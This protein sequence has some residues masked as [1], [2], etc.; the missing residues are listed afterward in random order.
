MTRD[1]RDDP[2]YTCSIP[3][4][5]SARAGIPGAQAADCSTERLLPNA[6]WECSLHKVHMRLEL[7]LFGQFQ[8][9]WGGQSIAFAANAARAVL[10]YL[11]LDP[12]RP[13]QREQ[14]AAL[15]WPDMPQAA[16][17][18]NL[19][20]VLSRVRKALPDVPDVQA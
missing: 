17:Y 2:G 5:G 11:A 13:H 16:A 15:L 6:A 20:Q 14:L 12:D 3:G 1:K 8:A 4:S 18:A 9:T 7:R 10:A 19:R